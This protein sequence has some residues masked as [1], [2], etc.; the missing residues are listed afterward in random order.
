MAQFLK[1]II[2]KVPT[3]RSCSTL[4][5]WPDFQ[6]FL[7]SAS[8]CSNLKY[9]GFQRLN[10]IIVQHHMLMRFQVHDQSLRVSGE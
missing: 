9:V 4:N 10:I 1:T 2:G 3:R 5:K 7:F 8:L 6:I